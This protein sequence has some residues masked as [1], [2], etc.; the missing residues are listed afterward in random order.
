MNH[1]EIIYIRVVANSRLAR[2]RQNCHSICT[3][4]T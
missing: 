2:C 3:L 4:Y 1:K